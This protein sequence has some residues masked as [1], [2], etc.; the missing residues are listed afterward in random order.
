MGRKE[1]GRQSS[2]LATQT[3]VSTACFIPF[4]STRGE[5]MAEI[6]AGLQNPRF[7]EDIASPSGSPEAELSQRFW[8]AGL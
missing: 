5:K 6:Q 2:A 1:G 7:Y 8:D 3:L 4:S